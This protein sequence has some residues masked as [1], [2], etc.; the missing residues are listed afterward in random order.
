MAGVSE[1]LAAVVRTPF[2]AGSPAS[3]VSQYP[4]AR[5]RA[6]RQ[7]GHSEDLRS[8][9]DQT[10]GVALQQACEAALKPPP[11]CQGLLGAI[12]L[13]EAEKD[14]ESFGIQ[15]LGALKLKGD[16]AKGMDTRAIYKNM[17]DMH[18]QSRRNSVIKMATQF[19][20]G[21]AKVMGRL[22]DPIYFQ[23]TG[24]AIWRVS[25][26]DSALRR[27]IVNV[28]AVDPD[29]TINMAKNQAE[30][31]LIMTA[32]S[33]AKKLYEDDGLGILKVYIFNVL[34]HAADGIEYLTSQQLL[35]QLVRDVLWQPDQVNKLYAVL[36]PVRS[37]NLYLQT[38]IL[39]PLKERFAAANG[40]NLSAKALQA[41]QNRQVVNLARL[42]RLAEPELLRLA[43][44]DLSAAA[45]MALNP[46][47]KKTRAF[48]SVMSDFLDAAGTPADHIYFMLSKAFN[49]ETVADVFLNPEKVIKKAKLQR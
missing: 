48:K 6:A 27:H 29:V 44:G 7:M 10:R 28:A 35:P 2:S 42:V 12:T 24:Q 20:A 18:G 33:S 25:L 32:L 26:A 45:G 40:S 13:Y 16:A 19:L 36:P 14:V 9:G 30:R 49:A 4:H 47:D 31:A 11:R 15:L 39:E 34:N 23:Q 46:S 8:I 21:C 38:Y 43:Q 17:V 37:D 3:S 41:I 22:G 5:P 1:W